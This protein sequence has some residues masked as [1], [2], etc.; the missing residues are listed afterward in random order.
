MNISFLEPKIWNFL[1]DEI[2]QQ[3]SLNSFKNLVKTGS[4]K[5][6]DVDCAKFRLMVLISC[7]TCHKETDLLLVL[8]L[9]FSP[10]IAEVTL[11]S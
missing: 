5:I 11:L 1:P 6:A 4:R 7:L 9:T 8:F 2:K 3:T 10:L